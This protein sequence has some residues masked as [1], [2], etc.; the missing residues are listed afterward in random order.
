MKI[1][2]KKLSLHIKKQRQDTNKEK[3]I[4]KL[5]IVITG[6]ASITWMPTFLNDLTQC[7]AMQ[8]GQLILN[9]IDSAGVEKMCKFGNKLAAERG[10]DLSIQ[11]EHDLEKALD[12][13]DFVVCTVLIGGHKNWKN[14]MNTLIKHGI[15]H[16]KG[17]SVGPGGLSMAFRQIPWIL[18]L[19]K[20]MEKIC[21]DAWLL[22][23]SNPMQTITYAVQ[24]Y[25][26]IKMLGLCHGVTHTVERLAKLI[27][28][29]ESDLFYTIGGVNHFEIIT[30]M[31]KDGKDVLEDIAGT[32]EK[33]QKE[34]GGTGE[35]I[36][37]ELYRLFG[38][39]PCN[40]DIHVIEFAPYY[41]HKNTDPEVY[42]Q[43]QNNIEER[44]LKGKEDWE[45]FDKY[46]S[47][48]LTVESIVHNHSEKLAEVINGITNNIPTYLY[49]NVMN[50]G[51]V[52]NLDRDMCVEVPLVVFRDGYIG[53]AVG[54]IPRPLAVMQNIHG[55]VQ[56][57]TVE[58][59]INGSKKDALIA[60]ALDPMCYTLTGAQREHLLSD[61]L[62]VSA[63]YLPD[64]LW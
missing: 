44:L 29:R 10:F 47:G 34:K 50:N 46:L 52:T 18:A 6:A 23:F 25:T 7:T 24:K 54:E 13:A 43:K 32:L 14:E 61:L 64:S 19:A 57:Y 59:A 36:T 1:K 48:E 27:D 35:I 9:D 2:E 28:C 55:A 21:P 51:Y 20:K 49:A 31:T 38:G 41:L 58:A 56:H 17:M 39:F 37:T 53:C 4:S 3:V 5:K 15:H 63:E 40:E 16:P 45:C 62:T 42:E 60:M 22:N 30:K 26:K 11:A 8:G 33:R 12:G